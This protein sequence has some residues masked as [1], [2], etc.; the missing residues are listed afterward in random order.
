MARDAHV[1]Y[2]QCGE[3]REREEGADLFDAAARGTACTSV[4][5][6]NSRVALANEKMWVARRR[7]AADSQ[8][9][10]TGQQSELLIGG[11]RSAP[12]AGQ[13]PCWQGRAS[14]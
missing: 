5:Q 6:A 14:A 11:K 3:S 10:A 8:G 7:R 9:Q 1:A 12:P 2:R 13:L 4:K